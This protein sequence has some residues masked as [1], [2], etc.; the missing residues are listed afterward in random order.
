MPGNMTREEHIERHKMLHKYF[1]ELAADF[2][3]KTG[4]LCSQSTIGDLMK[5]SHAQTIEPDIDNR[6]R[7]EDRGS[8]LNVENIKL[9]NQ[10]PCANCGKEI[11]P[12][13]AV[14]HIKTYPKRFC[15]SECCSLGSHRDDQ[16][17]DKGK[18]I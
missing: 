14:C 7:M 12:K 18:K 15:S 3:S 9:P 5:W 17:K 13:L 1:D 16:E 10:G 11:G 8:A 6:S 4:N 2:M